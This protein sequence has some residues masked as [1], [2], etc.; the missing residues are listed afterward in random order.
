MVLLAWQ[1]SISPGLCKNLIT[2]RGARG[3]WNW[4]PF[5]IQ[6]L[7]L[8]SLLFSSACCWI[9]PSTWNSS[10]YIKFSSRKF[11]SIPWFLNPTI[12]TRL[13]D[14]MEDH[15]DMDRGSIL[16]SPPH[17]AALQLLPVP[18]NPPLPQGSAWAGPGPAACDGSVVAELRL[19]REGWTPIEIV[20][21]KP[22][23]GRGCRR[24]PL[25][26]LRYLHPICLLNLSML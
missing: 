14:K 26:F 6:P 19:P 15:G 7:S 20:M 2:D 17:A 12:S 21:L 8:T 18:R 25:F 1:V 10:H 9:H 5:L 16:G 11:D 3:R 4:D 13:T 22:S 23:A 24:N